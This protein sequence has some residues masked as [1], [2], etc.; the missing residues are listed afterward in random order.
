MQNI[1]LWLGAAT[2]VAAGA[3]AK[4]GESP[5]SKTLQELTERVEKLEKAQSRFTEIDSFVRPIMAQ[6]KAQE[7]QREASEPDPAARFAV[8]IA[9]NQYDGPANAAVTI[10][11][12]WDF[13]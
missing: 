8:D 10:V 3:C 7:E 13:A 12:A 11:E 9:G 6:Q 4:G 2:I 5:D 1:T